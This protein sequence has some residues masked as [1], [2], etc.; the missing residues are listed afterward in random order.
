MFYDNFIEKGLF[1]I[2]LVFD[3]VMAWSRTDDKSFTEPIITDNC[4]S[5]FQQLKHLTFEMHSK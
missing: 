1:E 3:G 5:K 2:Y 4:V